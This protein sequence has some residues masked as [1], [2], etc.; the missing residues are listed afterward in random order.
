MQTA[1]P[2]IRENDKLRFVEI[3]KN[4]KLCICFSGELLL[5]FLTGIYVFLHIVTIDGKEIILH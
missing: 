2:R 3:L 4:G 5:R 1:C